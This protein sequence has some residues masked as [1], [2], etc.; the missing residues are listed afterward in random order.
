MQHLDE[1]AKKKFPK[2]GQM[3]QK[4]SPKSKKEIKRIVKRELGKKNEKH[5]SQAL[6][7]T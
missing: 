6:Q 7:Q 3:P 2:R 4:K 5:N 1:R